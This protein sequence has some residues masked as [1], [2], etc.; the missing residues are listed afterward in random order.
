MHKTAILWVV[1]A[2]LMGSILLATHG[3]SWGE[4]MEEGSHQG[5]MMKAKHPMGSHHGKEAFFLNLKQELG[6]TA[7][8]VQRLREI[9]NQTEEQAMEDMKALKKMKGDL[10]NLPGQETVNVAD[11]D[12]LLDEMGKLRTNLQKNRIHAM[13]EARNLLTVQQREKLKELHGQH[14]RKGQ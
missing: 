8:Q 11:V 3:E 10:H 4:M 6:L 5:M 7:E 2:F 9:K 14:P 13:I 1:T 12:A